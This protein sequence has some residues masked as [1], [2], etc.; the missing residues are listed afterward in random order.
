[1]CPEAVLTLLL[2]RDTELSTR[3][4]GK[5]YIK[6]NLINKVSQKKGNLQL[7]LVALK[8]NILTVNANSLY[9]TLHLFVFCKEVREYHI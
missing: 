1:M 6:Q 2:V 4:S 7:L 9:V 3:S 5:S 8:D